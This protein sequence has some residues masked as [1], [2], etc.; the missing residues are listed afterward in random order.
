MQIAFLIFDDMTTLDFLGVYD[1]VTRLKTMGFQPDLE[2]RVCARSAEVTDGT[3]LVIK[4]NLIAEP[5]T[6][7]DLVVVPGGFGTQTLESDP[8][9]ITWLRSAKDVPYKASVCTGS[10]LLG[11]AGFLQGKTATTHPTSYERLRKYCKHVSEERIVDEDGV[12]TAR[13]VTSSIDLGLFLVRKFAGA[14]IA[15]RIRKQMDYIAAVQQP[16]ATG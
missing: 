9:F 7:Y 15:E 8:E 16:A 6:D 3:G 2:W 1:A 14:D 5:L 4:A 13:G 11:A 10:L 12:V